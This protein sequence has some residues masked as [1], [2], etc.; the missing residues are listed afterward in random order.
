[1]KSKILI[2]FL[3]RENPDLSQCTKCQAE[4]YQVV[5]EA[6]ENGAA[7]TGDIL[8]RLNLRD[9]RPFFSRLN[10]LQEKGLIHWEKHQAM[11]S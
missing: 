2:Q 10:H 8:K 1:M 7:P 9:I 11:M 4:T 3:Q 5:R 6:T